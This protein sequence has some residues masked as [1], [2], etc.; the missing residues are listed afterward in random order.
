MTPP[1]R[2]LKA[3]TPVDAKGVLNFEGETF[4]LLFLFL[5]RNDNSPLLCIYNYTLISRNYFICLVVKSNV[6]NLRS[7]VVIQ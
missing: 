5:D 4:G 7:T 3:R 6:A 1:A 2:S